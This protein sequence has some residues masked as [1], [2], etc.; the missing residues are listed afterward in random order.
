MHHCNLALLSF[1]LSSMASFALVPCISVSPL[2]P[3]QGR[4]APSDSS[5]HTLTVYVPELL[6]R[7][8]DCLYYISGLDPTLRSGVADYIIFLA[9]L[10]DIIFW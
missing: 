10:Y 2:V 7:A 9:T 8:V 3:I 1:F 4:N 6:C 5:L